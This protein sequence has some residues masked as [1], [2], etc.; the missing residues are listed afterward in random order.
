MFHLHGHSHHGKRS[1]EA[2]YND[3]L[4]VKINKL[5]FRNIHKTISSFIKTK[6]TDRISLNNQTT[7]NIICIWCEAQTFL[8]FGVSTVTHSETYNFIELCHIL[9]LLLVSICLCLCCVIL[10]ISEAYNTFIHLHS[11]IVKSLTN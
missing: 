3:Y 11:S 8:E 4:S 6:G 9:K 5:N 1:T 2:T 7:K 10:M